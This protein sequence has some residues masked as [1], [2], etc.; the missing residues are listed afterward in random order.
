MASGIKNLSDYNP[1]EVPS[2]SG[3]RFGLVVTDYHTEITYA[4][5]EAAIGTLLK[6]G[7]S[8]ENIDEIH[9]PGT[10][11]LPLSAQH[12][13]EKGC[14]AVICIGCV[15]KGGTDH[16]KYINHA[17][18]QGI[19]NLNLEYSQ[20]VIF[21]VLTPNTMEQAKD[22][23]GGKHGNKGVEAALAAIKMVNLISN[24]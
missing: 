11:E 15:I 5:R 10:F 8:E 12:L 2:A 16:D 1:D 13:L 24:N 4:L 21:G 6:H 17:V 14:D 9:A 22:R 19:M 18:A 3:F 20:P 23:A 7:A